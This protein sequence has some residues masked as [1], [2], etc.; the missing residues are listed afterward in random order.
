MCNCWILIIKNI[1]I[2]W[3]KCRFGIFI[4]NPANFLLASYIMQMTIEVW[5]RPFLRVE[6]AKERIIIKFIFLNIQ[7]FNVVPYFDIYEIWARDIS[8]L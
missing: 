3:E 5:S 8:Q 2:V 4:Y 6:Y 7:T 1:K